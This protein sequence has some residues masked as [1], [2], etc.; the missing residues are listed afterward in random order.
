[1][2]KVYLR[3]RNIDEILKFSTKKELIRF[4]FAD[5]EAW[6]VEALDV[7][8]TSRLAWMDC[9]ECRGKEW[10]AALRCAKNM[11]E[12]R[13][14]CE[15]ECWSVHIGQLSHPFALLSCACPDENGSCSGSGRGPSDNKAIR[16]NGVRF[17]CHSATM[18]ELTI[19]LRIHLPVLFLIR[20]H[21]VRCG[22]GAVW[23]DSVPSSRSCTTVWKF[24][25][26][27]AAG[28]TRQRYSSMPRDLRKH[29]RILKCTV[30]LFT[31][32]KS[33]QGQGRGSK[34]QRVY[35][36]RHICLLHRVICLIQRVICLI[37][38]NLSVTE[39]SSQFN[40]AT[41]IVESNVALVVTHS[42]SIPINVNKCDVNE[43]K[44]ENNDT[45]CKSERI[46]DFPR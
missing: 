31:R 41:S 11:N 24:W 13:A 25:N 23:N 22:L 37:Q 34:M 3:Y 18:L 4:H 1:M 30:R 39:S 9:L 14:L 2:I 42:E 19:A 32:Q 38:C 33:V 12:W 46:N 28:T 35:S 27:H 7:R 8:G 20:H 10:E 43:S 17:P 15:D 21:F 44:T 36:K 6:S 40:T 45:I 16:V 26:L 29:S 5:T